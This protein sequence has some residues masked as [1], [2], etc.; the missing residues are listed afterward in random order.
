MEAKFRETFL[1]KFFVLLYACV[2]ASRL[3][4]ES[5]LNMPLDTVIAESSRTASIGWSGKVSWSDYEPRTYKVGRMGAVQILRGQF[6]FI[7]F[8]S[9]NFSTI[10]YPDGLPPEILAESSTRNGSS[11]T[12]GAKWN[13][14]V[15]WNGQPATWCNELKAVWSG[16]IE[17][18]AAENFTLRIDGNETTV[19]VL[20]VVE[21]GTWKR[22]YSGKRYQRF[23]WSP[24]FQTVMAIEFQT[25]NPLGKLHEA[26]YSMRVKEIQRGKE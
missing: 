2:V 13:G 17:V 18:E 20:P 8:N 3:H 19:P 15:I 14:E 12:S 22:C 6:G 16:S 23:L 25:Y 26:S 21:R 11:L 9:D 1:K 10:P 5:A 24:D 7:R 4:A